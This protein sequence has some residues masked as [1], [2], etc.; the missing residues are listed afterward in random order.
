MQAIKLRSHVGSDGILQIQ[1]PLE[2]RDVDLE[3]M[4]IVQPIQPSSLETAQERGWLPGFF[5]QTAG[6]MADDP[7]VRGE[8]GDYEEREA[9]L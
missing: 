9:L 3:V 7:L 1:L 6:A 4:V 8:Q 2:L 5:E